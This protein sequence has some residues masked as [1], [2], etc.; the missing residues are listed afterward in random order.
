MSSSLVVLFKELRRRRVFRVAIVYSIVGLGVGEGANN[1]LTPDLGVPPWVPFVIGVVVLLGFPVAL[2]LAWAY[3]ITPEGVV[4]TTTIEAPPQQPGLPP[5]ESPVVAAPDGVSVATAGQPRDVFPGTAESPSADSSI[6]VVPFSH[7]GG[8]GEAEAFSDGLTEELIS[9]LAH[10]PDLRVSG[11]TS[12]FALKGK[13]LDAR[14]IGRKLLVGRLV[15]GS[16]RMGGG[17]LRLSVQ[18]IDTAHGGTLWAEVYE[19]ELGDLF[20]L[21]A[22]M[23]GAIAEQLH[24]SMGG[25][26]ASGRAKHASVNKEA[27]VAYT[28][29]R[30]FWNRR[31]EESL[32][33]AVEH[34]QHALS[35][36]PEYALAHTGL[37]DTY[38]ILLDYGFDPPDRT[39]PLALRSAETAVALAPDLGEA[40]TSLALARQ[41]AWDWEGAD[42][43]FRKAI[44]V[45][46]S[47][48]VAR[49]R[50]ALF[51]AWTGRTEEAAVEIEEAELLDPLSLAV[52]ASVGWIHYYARDFDVAA[53]RLEGALELDPDFAS[54]LSVMGLIH[55]EQGEL[56]LA[57]ENHRRAVQ[58][59]GGSSASLSLL[60]YALGR[61]GELDEA[62]EVLRRLD[63][64]GQAGYVSSYCL[65]VP[66]LGLGNEDE[67]MELLQRALEERSA[68]LVYLKADPILDPLR[69]RPEFPPLLE[70]VG[71]P[72]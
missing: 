51:L 49:Q 31:T 68:N 54:G 25:S 6:A 19:K 27:H 28:R 12:A 72:K 13:G 23:A 57:V 10:M 18:L 41:F 21:Q 61:A 2:V 44:E 40:Q 24:P 36:A 26:R 7:M 11:S 69:E 8:E 38:A 48:A 30:Q 71:F 63:E 53:V 62:R 70:A 20:E 16:V 29:G 58:G 60:G 65:A 55:G 32:R 59:S 15:E 52:S 64:A 42:A 22:E 5:N 3:D 33:T 56:D 47:Y 39:L 45:A 50:Y 34:F 46:P 1:F 4:R 66:N 9:A 35:L 37:A 14:E 17:R 67:A 43:A